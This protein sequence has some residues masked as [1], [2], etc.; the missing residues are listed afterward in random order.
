MRC[1]SRA[2]RLMPAADTA[3]RIDPKNHSESFLIGPPRAASSWLTFAVVAVP[4]ALGTQVTKAE[5]LATLSPFHP[6]G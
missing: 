4:V 2:V 5:Q 1:T 3:R 6:Y